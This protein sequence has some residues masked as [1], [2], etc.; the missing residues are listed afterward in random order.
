M[1]RT[2][3]T[4]ALAAFILAAFSTTPVP[5]AAQPQ[6]ASPAR[7]SGSLRPIR[8]EAELRAL[9]RR[10]QAWREAN[11]PPPP[12][13]PPPP[14]PPP[15]PVPPGSM[16]TATAPSADGES[17]TNT[18]EAG[19][20]E[21][22][23]VKVRGNYLV[24]LRRGRLFTLS[25]ADG[26]M[27]AVDSINAYPPGANANRDWYDE[28]LVSG[29]WVVVIGYSYRRGGTEINRFRLS[30][31]G[32]LSFV[33][34]HHLRSNDYY[35]SSNYASRLI[36][37]RL[38]FYTPLYLR[39]DR[40]VADV[41]PG[42]KR[43][44][45]DET[46][47]NFRPIATPRQI[48]YSP[49]MMRNPDGVIT[50]LHSVT[51]CDLTA[52]ELDCSAIGVLG[53]SSR[54]FYVSPTG[55]YLWLSA[56]DQEQSRRFPFN[57][58]IFRLP[59]AQS[60]RPSAVGAR[61][62]VHD[63]FAFRE[64]AA[65][66]V[67]NVLVQ[68]STYGAE[69]WEP[70]APDRTVALI[71]VPLSE[72]NDGSREVRRRFYRLLPNPTRNYLSENR[73]VGNHVL[74]GFRTDATKSVVVAAALNAPEAAEVELD[75]G[76]SRI[77]QIGRDALIVGDG[78]ERSLRFT[79]IELG[80]PRA[81]LGDGY[82]M[83]AATE[84]EARSHAFFYNPD[85][86]SPDGASGIMGLPIARPIDGRY[87][88]LTRSAAGMLF[89]RREQREFSPLGTLDAEVRGLVHDNCV[90]S[91]LD[92]YGNARPI[93]LRG[94]IFALLGYELVE[95]RVSQADRIREIGRLNFA[96]TPATQASQP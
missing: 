21:G 52:A 32:R 75:Q 65:E 31:D 55:V 42:I 81:R 93:F 74:Y 19:V 61:G 10:L 36:G 7:P 28:M 3:F 73:Y 11:P 37:N 9:L 64:D 96:P 80:Q 13:P 34:A 50:T 26:G 29:D 70:E 23:I 47:R 43:W 95:G 1:R 39:Y 72:F 45:G 25:I 82:T 12:P 77:E 38:I 91:C 54:Q 63:Q 17:I 57:R 48:F 68:A 24:V 40:N 20:D 35:S 89:L 15:P 76:L 83:P 67:L 41:L 86:A 2:M 94:R 46:D 5:A 87:A 62:G 27:R 60:E 4:G 51:T 59:F 71:R 30:D 49:Q 84:G 66:G 53:P 33:D 69:L 14:A 56:D 85:P 78:P 6:A 16:T 22:G 79:A 58:Y 88:G 92:W 90:A 8:S 44:T 18:Q